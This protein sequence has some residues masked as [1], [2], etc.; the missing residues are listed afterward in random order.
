M[1]SSFIPIDGKLISKAKPPSYKITELK[2]TP[3]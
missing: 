2:K 3:I 1:I